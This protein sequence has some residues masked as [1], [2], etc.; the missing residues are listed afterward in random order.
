MSRY[1]V[2]GGNGVIGHFV[3][4]ALVEAGHRPV[5]MSRSGNTELINDIAA[6][7]DLLTGDASAADSVDAAI[8]AHGITHIA[9]LGATL[10][11]VTENTPALGMQIN[12]GGAANVLEAARKHGVKR[13]VMASS[14][15][16][17]SP[18][19][20]EFAHP[21]YRPMPE[22]APAE[23]AT[24]Y[25][26]SKL[27]GELLGRW[28]RDRHG[29]EFAALRFGSTI[30]PGKISRHG[31]AH[32]RYSV[33][34]ENPMAGLPA[35][36]PKGGDAVCD[37]LF[38]GEVARGIISALDAP[39]LNHS[40][41]NIATGTG[42]TLKQFGAAV[43]RRFPDAEISIGPGTDTGS[44]NC[45]LDVSRAK[46]DLGFVADHDVDRIVDGYIATMRRLN[47]QAPAPH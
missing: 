42:F 33:I 4:R 25:G 18:I 44:M 34:M 35:E 13:V 40:V 12:V 11:S 46:E 19:S 3:T 7:C 2:I 37:A 24:V 39:R 36:I 9:H 30:G 32:S 6:S 22:T 5:V 31:G 27:A 28:F 38:N 43:K 29:V 17:Y 10:T 16:A 15:A 47:L 14:K 21:T 26:I 1:L 23:P 8:S 45:I 41:Y 20:G